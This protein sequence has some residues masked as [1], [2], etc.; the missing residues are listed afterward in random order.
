MLSLIT[1]GELA[2]CKS[3][4]GKAMKERKPKKNEPERSTA[5]LGQALKPG[6]Y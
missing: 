2:G 6:K 4:T 5:M 3:D 1:S